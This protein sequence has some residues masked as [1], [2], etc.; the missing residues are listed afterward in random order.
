MFGLS[1][2]ALRE[3]NPMLG[4]RGAGLGI[5]IPELVEMQVRA[6]F[7]AACDVKKRGGSI[8]TSR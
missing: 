7:E 3:D 5:H 6:I 2:E 8:H 4:L 1:W